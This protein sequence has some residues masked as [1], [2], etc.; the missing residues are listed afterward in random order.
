MENLIYGS[1]GILIGGFVGYMNGYMRKKA[2]NRAIHEDFQ[3]VLAELKETTHATKEIEAKISDEVW[4]RQ[5]KWEIKKEA[6]FDATRGLVDFNNALIQLSSIDQAK[7]AHPHIPADVWLL[8]ENQVMKT[9]MEATSSLQ[10][11]TLLLSVTV[12]REVL[13]V[14]SK[15]D[16]I[17]KDM[18]SKMGSGDFEGARALIDPM[19]KSMNDLIA[20]IRAELG[21][22]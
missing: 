14:F 18:S 19:R 16:N 6:L 22:D 4:N 2:E 11:I 20:N 3:A 5:R 7:K 9:V 8:Q 1:L 10:Q 12:G 15:T 13:I 21:V 17:L